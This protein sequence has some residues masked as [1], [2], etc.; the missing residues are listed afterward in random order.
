MKYAHRQL[1]KEK[2]EAKVTKTV[3]VNYSAMLPQFL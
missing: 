1:T 3:N 2:G